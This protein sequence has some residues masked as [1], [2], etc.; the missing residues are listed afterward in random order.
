MK[1]QQNYV[2]DNHFKLI[3]LKIQYSSIVKLKVVE[4]WLKCLKWVYDY[5]ILSLNLTNFCWQIPNAIMNQ[6]VKQELSTASCISIYIKR[7]VDPCH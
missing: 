6:K 1:Q 2:L 7:D 3:W 4:G 5:D